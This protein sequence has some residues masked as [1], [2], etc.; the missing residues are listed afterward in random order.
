[1]TRKFLHVELMPDGHHVDPDRTTLECEAEGCTNT[2]LIA[3]SHS[4]VITFATTGP[5][6]IPSFQC[7]EEQ[8]FC[9]SPECAL[10][11]GIMC[12][13]DHLTPAHAAKVAA[14]LAEGMTIGDSAL[15]R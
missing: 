1:M 11:A 15:P 10:Q 14:R 7:S 3:T 13:R 4:F 6:H 2:V 12:M 8:H 5:Y 9:C